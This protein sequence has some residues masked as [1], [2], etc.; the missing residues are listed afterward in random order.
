LRFETSKGKEFRR[1]Y[2]ENIQHKKRAGGVAQVVEHLLSKHEASI[3]NPS[4]SK[5]RRVSEEGIH[6]IEIDKKQDF[7]VLS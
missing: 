5:K 3:S 6:V 7:L 2:L 1:P 4:P